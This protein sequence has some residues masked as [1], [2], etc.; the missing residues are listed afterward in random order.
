MAEVKAASTV[1]KRSW[2]RVIYFFD[3]I[4]VGKT[5]LLGALRGEK[6][7]ENRPTTHGVEVDIKSFVVRVPE[8][9]TEIILNAWDFGGQ[10]IYRHTHQLFFTA[11]AI[12]LALWNPRRG[13]ESCLV[14]EWVKM[15]KH[16]A[17]DETRP[18]Q[19]PRILVVATHGS[20]ERLDHIDK[21]TFLKEF[22]NLIK[23]F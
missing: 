12:Y 2:G 16:R 22:G 20:E 17:Y 13:A 11:P 21:T 15:V 14:E 4:E 19:K 10:N 3:R 6:F 7:V 5:S 9:N 23:D 1:L 8:N 18:Q